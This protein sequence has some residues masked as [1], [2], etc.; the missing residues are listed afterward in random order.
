MSAADQ[1]S[2]PVRRRP[3]VAGVRVR[4]ILG[5]QGVAVRVEG[6]QV[7]VLW[8]DNGE[9]LIQMGFIE[10]IPAASSD[11]RIDLDTGQPVA[12]PP[13]ASSA[14]ITGRSPLYPTYK[15]LLFLDIAIR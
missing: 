9:E 14:L 11:E 5:A 6:N 15:L 3:V 10:A 8:D 1:T 7:F 2:K 13:I 12:Q 4:H